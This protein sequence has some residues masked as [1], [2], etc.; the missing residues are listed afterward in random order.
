MAARTV[1]NLVRNSTSC[2]KHSMTQ[3]TRQNRMLSPSRDCR[4]LHT[5]QAH[6]CNMQRTRQGKTPAAVRDGARTA[7]A[8]A[9]AQ[10]SRCT[11]VCMAVHR[12][13]KLP[14]AVRSHTL[15]HMPARVHDLLAGRG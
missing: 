10:H 4:A 11:A 7:A 15:P 9:A 3:D 13:R 8:P 2:M 6:V 1:A 12:A 5:A 14:A